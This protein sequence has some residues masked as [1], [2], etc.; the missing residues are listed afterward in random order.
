MKIFLGM[1]SRYDLD[2]MGSLE[3]P[4]GLLSIAAFV[5][6]KHP[7]WTI[8]ILYG[9]ISVQ[10]IL[11]FSPDIIGLSIQSPFFTMGQN[12]VHE[13]RRMLPELP[14][15]IGG[16]HI[17]YL[18]RELPHDVTAGVVGEGERVFLRICEAVHDSGGLTPSAMAA[19]NGIVFWDNGVLRQTETNADLLLPDEFPLID[20]Y[21]LCGFTYHKPI[22][23][24][25]TTSRGCP[26]RCRFC[27]SSPF[28]RTVRYQSAESVV[29]QI[30]Y[31]VSNFNP[32]HIHIFDDLMIAKKDRL[33][34][35]RDMVVA[36]GLHRK[37]DFSCW[38]TGIHF[39]K[40]TAS[41]LKDMNVTT[42]N[43]AVESGSARIYEYLKGKWNSPQ[44]NADAIRFAHRQGF[45]VGVS[46][47]VGSPDETIEEMQI[48]HDFVKN[49]P[50]DSGT[51]SLLK[52]YPG[53]VIW[54]ETKQR[55]VVHDSMDDWH[56]IEL[57]D[58]SNPRTLLLAETASRS[59]VMAYYLKNIKLLKHK[60]RLSSWKHRLSLSV[61]P[62]TALRTIRSKVRRRK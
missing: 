57:N 32:S 62:V 52:P 53:T 28:W 24:H 12:L 18:P 22:L 20:T 1:I 34:T 54:E 58:L 14:I 26:Y 23:Y 55:G 11:S 42:V 17:T 44:K 36:Q 33:K 45:R 10:D 43:F 6:S 59:D 41:L 4:L 25:I 3:Y 15:V 56:V 37:V 48:T 49:L 13:L 16:H 7:D 30:S 8:K 39:D 46:V 27:S 35:I 19:I 5:R 21:K 47:I 61:H 51:V 60:E 38:V 29:R 50:I 2:V 40:E 31:I 9:N